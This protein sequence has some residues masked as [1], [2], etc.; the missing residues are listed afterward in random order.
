MVKSTTSKDVF[1][2][3]D[4]II[5]QLLSQQRTLNTGSLSLETNKTQPQVAHGIR[6]TCDFMT[7][8]IHYVRHESDKSTPGGREVIRPPP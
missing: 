7:E 3:D 1:P 6:V 8:T 4:V 2:D 5:V